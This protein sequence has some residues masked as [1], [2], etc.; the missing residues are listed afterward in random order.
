M[1]F[2]GRQ[3][4]ERHQK[5]EVDISLSWQHIAVLFWFFLQTY[6]LSPNISLVQYPPWWSNEAGASDLDGLAQACHSS[7]RCQT[8]K[9]F[10]FCFSSCFSSRDQ[11]LSSSLIYHVLSPCQIRSDAASRSRSLCCDSAA[12]ASSISVSLWY[13]VSVR[14]SSMPSLVCTN[15]RFSAPL[16]S[17]SAV[18]IFCYDYRVAY[19]ILSSL[20]SFHQHLD[21]EPS[22]WMIH[23]SSIVLLPVNCS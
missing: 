22:T 17:T 1:I 20:F 12:P 10:R 15:K 3:P 4:N 23:A 6:A 13:H 14:I 8:E 7:S 18:T 16:P 19:L 21:S 11:M 9:C 5:E 2:Q